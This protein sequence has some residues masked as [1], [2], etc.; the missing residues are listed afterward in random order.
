MAEYIV[1]DVS[2]AD[3]GR[4]ELDICDCRKPKPGMIY[5]AAKE[6]NI[7][8]PQSYLIGDKDSDVQA[9]FSAGIKNSYKVGGM[10][11]NVKTFGNLSDFSVEF[12]TSHG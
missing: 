4:K 8:L 9:G 7:S 3:F 6:F 12:A 10:N 1:K 2:L 11:S 5:S